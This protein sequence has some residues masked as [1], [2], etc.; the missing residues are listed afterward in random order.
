MKQI[1]SLF[2]PSSVQQE[3]DERAQQIDLLALRDAFFAVMLLVALLP[4][5]G[6]FPFLRSQSILVWD[7]FPVLV[8]LSADL[9]LLVSRKLRGGKQWPYVYRTAVGMVL[10]IPGT[11]VVFLV[12]HLISGKP[13]LSFFPGYILFTLLVSALLWLMAWRRMKKEQGEPPLTK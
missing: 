11:A 12:M 9:V 6:A 1:R 7:V 4:I 10:A 13:P 3:F 5:A 2:S 8:L